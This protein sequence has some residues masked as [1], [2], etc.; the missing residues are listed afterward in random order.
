MKYGFTGWNSTIAQEMMNLVDSDG[1]T[2]GQQ[3]V[4]YNRYPQKLPLDCDRYVFCSGFLAGKNLGEITTQ[5]VLDTMEANFIDIAS[6]CDT[7]I[8]ENRNA[9]ICI[10]GSMSAI[11]GSYDMV[12]AAA[13]AG[14]HLYAE[15]KRLGFRGQHLVCI[16]P[17]VIMDSGMTQRRDD[18]GNV[19]A[20][21]Q[22]RR[23]CRWLTAKE[24][25]EVALFALQQPSMCNT[26]V[27][28]TGGNW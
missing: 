22:A 1:V 27:K 14:I 26:V 3:E 4:V 7:I 24:V 13:K 23:L 5:N 2:V 9:S 18:V 15:T 17:T 16:A 25:A 19:E 20:R 21:A 10:I 12:Y 11:N 6:M 28:L 8:E